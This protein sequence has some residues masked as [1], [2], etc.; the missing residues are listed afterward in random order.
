VGD[1]VERIAGV[2]EGLGH[3]VERADPAYGLVGLTFLPRS[4]GGLADWVAR[5]PDPALLDARTHR[6]ARM[7]RALSPSLSLSRAAEG[8]FRRR[9]GRI[10]RSF[11]V[12]L[13]PTTAK[14]PAAG[15]AYDG[16]D[17]PETNKTMVAACPYAWPWNVLGWPG[18]GVPARGSRPLARTTAAPARVAR[19]RRLRRT[20]VLTTR[21]SSTRRTVTLK[22]NAWSRLAVMLRLTKLKNGSVSGF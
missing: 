6:T 11:D 19:S 7:G 22:P 14:P 16:L 20:Y 9:V 18:V 8:P 13:A 15:R 17:G 2:L 4:A 12:V 1:A 3:E 21:G 10:F 5:V